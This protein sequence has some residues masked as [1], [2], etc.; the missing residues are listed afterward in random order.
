MTLGK[1]HCQINDQTFDIFRNL[2][3]FISRLVNYKE[4]LPITAPLK[5]LEHCTA[6]FLEGCDSDS[7][8]KISLE[9]WGSCLGL[10]PG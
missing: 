3:L 5:A 4:L 10:D 2:F 9:E 7:D 8:G 6:P 1:T